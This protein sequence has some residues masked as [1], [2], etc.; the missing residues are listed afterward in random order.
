MP[1][2]ALRSGFGSSCPAIY[3]R[4]FVKTARYIAQ[5]AF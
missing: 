1:S 2:M 4:A 5:S 3:G